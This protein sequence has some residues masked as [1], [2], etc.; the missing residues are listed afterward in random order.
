MLE[1]AVRR[2]GGPV[3]MV[4]DSGGDIRMARAY[5]CPVVWAG[6]GYQAEAPGTPDAIA[7][8]PADL[9]GAVQRILSQQS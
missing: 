2:C 4:G 7:M 1:E 9:P 6:W 8:V 3:I 5:G